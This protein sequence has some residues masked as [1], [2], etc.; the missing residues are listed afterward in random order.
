VYYSQPERDADAKIHRAEDH[1]FEEHG[2]E[3]EDNFR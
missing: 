2:F 1:G 3:E